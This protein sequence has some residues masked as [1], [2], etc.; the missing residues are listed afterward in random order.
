MDGGW[1]VDRGPGQDVRC[2]EAS[3]AWHC[4]VPSPSLLSLP[5]LSGGSQTQ[6][7]AVRSR[8]DF[9]FPDSGGKVPLGVLA[10]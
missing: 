9:F 4:F 2:P 6:F 8:S 7:L 5:S 3:Q 1:C 10:F